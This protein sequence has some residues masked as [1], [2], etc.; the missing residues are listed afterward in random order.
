LGLGNH[1]L[2]IE[3]I[4]IVRIFFEDSAVQARGFVQLT[5][6]MQT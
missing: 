6:L 4:A 5:S 3:G 2:E 1:T